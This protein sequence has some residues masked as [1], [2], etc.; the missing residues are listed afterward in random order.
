[1]TAKM[2][3]LPEDLGD[4]YLKKP[5]SAEWHA[6]HSEDRTVSSLQRPRKMPALAAKPSFSQQRRY[7]T[8]ATRDGPC[9]IEIGLA[10]LSV[11][12]QVT[13]QRGQE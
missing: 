2:S 12:Q 4:Q 1:M 6:K 10:R 13:G 7:D 11:R 5:Q 3:S 9:D 8:R